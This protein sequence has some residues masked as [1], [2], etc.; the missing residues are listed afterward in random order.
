[1]KLTAESF[2]KAPSRVVN[3]PS[4][5]ELRRLAAGQ[6]H[7][8]AFGAP[9]YFTGR[10]GSRSA[11]STFFVE[12]GGVRLGRLQNRA[13]A[14]LTRRVVEAVDAAVAG[15]E[16]LQLDRAV[17]VSPAARSHARLLITSDVARVALLWAQTLF[18]APVE[19]N[20]PR[21]EP[22]ILTIYCPDWLAGLPPESRRGLPEKLILARPARGVNYVLGVDYV[23]ECKMSF[24]RMAMYQMKRKGG[25]GLHAGSKSI[26]VRTPRGLED[27]GFLLFGLSGTGKTTLTLEDHGLKAPEGVRVLQDDIVLLDR[28]GAAYGTENNFYVKTEGLTRE[29]QPGLYDALL[30]AGSV[31]ENVTLDPK[32]RQ[33]LFTDYRHGTNGRALALRGRLP[34][35]GGE[36]EVDLPK[37]HKLVFITRRDTVVPP[38]ARLDRLQAAAFFML[39][40]SIETSAGDAS[41]AGQPKHEVGFNPFIVGPEEEEARRL[42]DVL[43]AHPEI[44]VYLLNTGSVG[45]GAD[46]PG[47]DPGGVKIVKDLSSH[48]LQFVARQ[49]PGAGSGWVRD[50]DWGYEV[51]DSVPGAADYA[52]YD[53]RKF[54]SPKTWARLNEELRADRRAYLDQ[55]PGLDARVRG[56]V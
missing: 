23:G 2:Q 19:W 47:A 44:E 56:R 24:L 26:R 12:E 42:L 39:G 15:K 35:S 28:G 52:R 38:L 40:E 31:F 3:N 14:E 21:K 45:K 1:M 18:P 53:P 33:A 5:T 51:P 27:A 55:F 8:T 43:E 17:G 54:Y 41:K 22:D 48:L 4:L 49:A 46:A 37:A 34:N 11:G 10:A 9:A 25:L 50:P 20:D 30:D 16:W 32:T 13:E 7:T 6:E 36:A 29:G